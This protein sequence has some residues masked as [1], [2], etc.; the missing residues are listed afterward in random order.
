MAANVFVSPSTIENSPNSVGEAMITGTPVVSS[1]VGGTATMLTDGT[2]GILYNFYD[3]ETLIN[4]I[5]TIFSNRE[6]AESFSANA[7]SHAN[8]THNRETNTAAM[9]T[10]YRTIMEE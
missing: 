9:L 4:G 8:R 7:I 5:K 3:T 1:N 6:K 2:D 10:V